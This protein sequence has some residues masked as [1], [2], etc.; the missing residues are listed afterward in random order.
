MTKE[1]V[2]VKYKNLVEALAACEV[3]LTA[4]LEKGSK[5]AG[6]RARAVLREAKKSAGDVVKALVELE[7]N[8][9]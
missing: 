3:D 8:P 9:Q 1:E 7:K 5:A 4:S 6:R 2:L